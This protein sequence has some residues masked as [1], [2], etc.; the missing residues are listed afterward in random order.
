MKRTFSF[1]K[2]S[3]LIPMPSSQRQRPKILWIDGVGSYAMCDAH[4][5]SI[6]QA[7][8]E[9]QVDLA[10]RADISRKACIIRRKGEDHL[11]QP[12]QTTSLN[13]QI[14]ERPAIL[15]SGCTLQIGDR[16]QLRYTRPTLLS[17]TARLEL[18]SN[19]RWQ[20]VLN[21]VILLGDSCVIG[22]QSDAH[23][24][25]LPPRGTDWNGRFIWFR[26]SDSW[27]CKGV[28]CPGLVVGQQ[29]VSA[30]FKLETGLRIQ[31][32]VASWTLTEP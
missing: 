15:K 25:C 28:E 27:I 19:H 6:G 20:P 30:P 10:I 26:Q 3:L 22:P 2:P 17:G 21:S 9:N 32:D 7:F 14:L 12:F 23:I 16:V 4:E 5:V 29:S 8:P 31:S 11:I 18:V 13:G 24:V 1:P